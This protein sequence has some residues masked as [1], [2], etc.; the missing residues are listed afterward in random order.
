MIESR[1]KKASRNIIIG[2][3]SKLLI[4]LFGFATK[5]IFVRL[6]GV[7]YNG[8]SGLYT[9]ILA[10]LALSELGVGNVLNYSLYTALRNQDEEK[11]KDLVSF[12]KKIYLGI[13]VA[14]SVLG[15]ALVPFLHFIINSDLPVKDLITYYLL[16]LANS[17]V[18]YFVVY[19]TA[20]ISA[21]QNNYISSICDIVTTILMYAVQIIFL[22]LYKSFLGYLIIQVSFTFI[23]NMTMNLMTNIKYPY[24]RRLNDFKR[25]LEKEEKNK[26]ITNIKSTFMYK[27][28]AVIL[29]STDN[30]LISVIVG[31][32]FVG[33]Y[34]N[35]YLII[36]YM[37]AF[38]AVFIT[39]ITA[40]L[41]NLNSEKNPETSYRMFNILCLI[42]SFIGITGT[43]CFI[44]CIQQFIPIWIGS[45]HVM[46]FS[47]VIIIALNFYL[48]TLMNPIWLFRETMG[49][50]KQVRYLML[51]TAGLNIMFSLVFGLFF[52]VP[53]IIAATFMAKLVSQYWYEPKVLFGKF[54]QRVS[55]FYANQ[56]KQFTVAIG[57]TCIS[58][59]F[60]LFAGSGTVGMVL[61]LFI[62]ATI[63]AI[64]WYILNRDTESMKML[65]D[66]Y[67]L[68]TVSNVFRKV[69]KR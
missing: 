50:F 53:G 28:A 34:S 36:S 31:T 20:V 48:N 23:K 7:E 4:M 54:K 63:S 22:L 37:S 24:L 27:V 12:F 68:P 15:L 60:C 30:I 57:S 43:C 61:R 3:L 49:L 17:V 59:Y 42:F 18:S 32:V 6:L 51:I 2:V 47:W 55:K 66:T 5:T 64:C 46:G 38:I 1:T 45:E 39:G 25:N 19:K 33:Y 40:G 56:F 69:S 44:N 52:G 35:Y 29:N 67:I 9:N 14:I 11:V 21:D 10:V 26:L 41:G 8:V 16:Y 65:K 62:S 13:A 58:Y